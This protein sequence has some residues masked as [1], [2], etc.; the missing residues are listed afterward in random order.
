MNE[1]KMVPDTSMEV[2]PAPKVDVSKLNVAFPEEIKLY[3]S[4]EL[5]KHRNVSFVSIRN[6]NVV[7]PVWDKY[8]LKKDII[9]WFQKN[10][11]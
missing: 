7:I 11:L 5:N 4:Y 6:G 9:E 10:Y 8:I 2:S 3:S 1:N